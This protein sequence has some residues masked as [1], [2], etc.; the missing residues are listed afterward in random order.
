MAKKVT[1]SKEDEEFFGKN[2]SFGVPKFDM[3]MNGEFLAVSQLL[4]SRIQVL[5]LNYLLS[6]LPRLLKSQTTLST[7]Q[8]M[9]G[10]KKSLEFTRNTAGH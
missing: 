8:Q 7:Y 9:K 5:V 1:F 4:H 2:G 10:N 6:N 3:E